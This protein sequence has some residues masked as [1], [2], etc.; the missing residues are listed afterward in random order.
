MKYH[1]E[2]VEA[3]GNNALPYRTVGNFQQG[4]VS[5]SN[6]QCSGRP[7]SVRTDLALAVI[8]QLMYE[9]K[10]WTPLEL[11]RASD[12]EKCTVHRILRNELHLPR[13]ASRWVAHVLTE[14]QR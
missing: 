6:E 5:T 1:C 11:E 12:I 7:V 4:R 8:E 2:L 9:D 10:R 13:I 14:V 3:V